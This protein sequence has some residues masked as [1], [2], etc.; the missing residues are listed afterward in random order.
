M[1]RELLE[2][3]CIIT[4]VVVGNQHLLPWN[5]FYVHWTVLI[6]SG[7]VSET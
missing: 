2:H 6:I 7:I 4:V 1:K 5:E 3:C